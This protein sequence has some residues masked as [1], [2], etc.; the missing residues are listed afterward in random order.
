MLKEQIKHMVDRFLGWKLPEDFRPDAGISFKAAYN[1]HTAYQG[2]HEPS[3]TNLFDAKQA[4]MMVRHMVEGLP[5]GDDFR[6]LI[7][8]PGPKYLAVQVLTANSTFEWTADHNRALAFRSQEQAD[9]A[10]AAL[11]QMDR[12]LTA[13]INHGKLS[14]GDLFAFEPTLGNAKAVEH[15]WMQ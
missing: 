4:D 9:S 12:A 14:W 3:G 10:L 2:K 8:A 5:Q 11:R 1:E 15:G 13:K 6:W 7:E